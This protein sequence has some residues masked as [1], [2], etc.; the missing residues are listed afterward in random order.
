MAGS[1][2]VIEFEVPKR[3]VYIE[4]RG[5]YFQLGDAMNRLFS[6]PSIFSIMGSDSKLLA[7][8]LDDPDVVPHDKLRSHIG[9]FVPEISKIPDQALEGYISAGRYAK[10]TIRG[11]YG[12]VPES[13]HFFYSVW[14]PHSGERA[15]HGFPG[16][17]VYVNN[18]GEVERE[19]LITELYIPLQ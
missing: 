18:P 9:V 1:V 7:I 14:L 4:Q 10:M 19:D 5:P 3:Y 11:S 8:W 15:R 17:E 13:W 12:T 6:V 2:E 16:F